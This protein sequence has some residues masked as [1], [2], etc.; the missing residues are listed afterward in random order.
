MVEST[1]TAQEAGRIT[2]A[3]LK[4][5]AA[6]LGFAACGVTDVRP[7]EH[8]AFLRQWLDAGRHGSMSYLSRDD[9]VRARTRPDEAWPQLRTAIVLAVDYHDGDMSASRPADRGIIARYAR[10][11]DYH[12]V[13]RKKLFELLRWLEKETGRELPMA[14]A[15]VDTGPVLERELAQRAGLGWFGR[16]TMMLH[17][18]RGSYFFLATLLVELDVDVHDEPFVAD[19][20]GTCNACV[21]ACP[22]GA[23]LGRD[24]NGAPVI[25]AT[26]C[27][28]YQTIEN[29]GPIP[30]ELRP[31]IG[32]RVFGCDIC[33]EVCPW[34][35]P[36]FVS[37]TREPD[38]NGRERDRE[39][40]RKRIREQR[41]PLPDTSLPSL[42][43]L[44]RMTWAD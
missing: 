40:E 43:S 35:G 44:M 29:R 16:N 41:D 6:R 22:T 17:P 12:K 1:A 2:T 20:C 26:R 7:S 23:L 18:R 3:A 30:R 28:S 37:L 19:H 38:F 10:G 33:Q 32:N 42:I 14:R 11:R 13:I 15:Y 27:I 31:L 39:R 8:A 21:D 25:D 24:E 5:E 9:A 34:N 36:K 4:A